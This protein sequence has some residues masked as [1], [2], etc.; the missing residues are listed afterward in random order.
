MAFFSDANLESVGIKPKM[1]LC[2]KCG[3]SMVFTPGEGFCCP[4]GHGCEWPQ[5]ERDPP[6]QATA[7]QGNTVRK[8]GGSSKGRKRKK[9][10]KKK[11]WIG[12]YGDS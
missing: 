3:R 11:Q 8:K 9:P 10:A 2:D 6:T 7:C 1:R 5:E 4:A 12:I